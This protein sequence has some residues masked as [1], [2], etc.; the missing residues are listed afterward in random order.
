MLWAKSI[1]FGSPTINSDALP[2]IWDILT[3]LNPIVHGKKFASAFG[4]Y[5]WSGEAVKNIEA[6]LKQL[7]FKVIPGL[8]VEFKPSNADL[9]KISEYAKEFANDLLSK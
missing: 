5:G 4:S 1:L 9:I 2:P 6:R 8:R 3:N 7:R